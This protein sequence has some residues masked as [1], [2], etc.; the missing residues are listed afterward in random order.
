[1][2][3]QNV[4]R[5]ILKKE[6]ATHT[7][8][9]NPADLVATRVTPAHLQQPFQSQRCDQGSDRGVL[10]SAGQSD[11]RC[12]AFG[13]GGYYRCQIEAAVDIGLPI[14]LADILAELKL[15]AN[16]NLSTL[17]KAVVAIVDAV[18]N[19]LLSVLFRFYCIPV[20]FHFSGLLINLLALIKTN[21]LILVNLAIGEIDVDIVAAIKVLVEAL[22]KAKIHLLDL[23][24]SILA[25]I[26]AKI[27]ANLEAKVQ[28]DVVAILALTKH[29]F[30]PCLV[31]LV[32]GFIDALVAVL[33]A[34]LSLL[35]GIHVDVDV[36]LNILGILKATVF[37]I[38]DL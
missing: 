20:N 22:I 32:V 17:L 12:T 13:L 26:L 38:I 1:M 21:I 10:A 28:V 11:C 27:N 33:V 25:E 24:I 35:H 8:P 5:K 6:N 29:G 19:I 2:T 14:S 34:I 18:L 7:A 3:P 4:P 23:D 36:C 15:D 9:A 37:A 31:A 16:L 30:L